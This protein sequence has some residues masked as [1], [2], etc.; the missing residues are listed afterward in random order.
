MALVMAA[1]LLVF[2]LGTR[3]NSAVAHGGDS[4]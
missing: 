3:R 1:A 4:S 2:L